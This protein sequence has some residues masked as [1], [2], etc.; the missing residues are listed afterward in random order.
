M[1]IVEA[2]IVVKFYHNGLVV[3]ILAV[4]VK[5]KLTESGIWLGVDHALVGH[6]IKPWLYN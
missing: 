6:C 2:V 3:Q 4:T 1:Q 5:D